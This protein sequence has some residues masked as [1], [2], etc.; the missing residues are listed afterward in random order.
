MLII[1]YC[2]LQYGLNCFLYLMTGIYN[3]EIVC[4]LLECLVIIIYSVITY[5][6]Y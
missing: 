2:S 5:N 6:Q 4:L 1:K 3:F